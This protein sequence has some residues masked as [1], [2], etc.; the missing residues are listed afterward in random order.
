MATIYKY[1]TETKEELF[2]C[3]IQ[4]L[5]SVKLEFLEDLVTQENLTVITEM[6][7]QAAET[8][9]FFLTFD[10]VINWFYFGKGLGTMTIQG[11]ILTGANKD[12]GLHT[13]LNESMGKMRGKS[14]QASVGNIVFTGVL[15]NFSL[16]FTQDP[17]PLVAFSLSFV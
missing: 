3:G 10:D 6:S 17:A 16:N 15:T 4:V 12:A 1:D 2:K 7:I 14:V 13:F 9:Q 11:L 8:V 5:T